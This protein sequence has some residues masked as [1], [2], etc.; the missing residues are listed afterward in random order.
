[1]KL[2]SGTPWGRL[3]IGA[4]DPEVRAA[5]EDTIPEGHTVAVIAAR[6]PYNWTLILKRGTVELH[7]IQAGSLEVGVERLLALRQVVVEANE[8]Y[9]VVADA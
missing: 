1:M 8:G 9:T 5:I 3:A 7:R 2:V 6:E 4:L